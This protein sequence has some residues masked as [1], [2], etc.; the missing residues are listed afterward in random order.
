MNEVPAVK[1]A[2]VSVIVKY[3]IPP[4]AGVAWYMSF[5]CWIEA[6][7]DTTTSEQVL[8]YVPKPPFDNASASR[9]VA[10]SVIDVYVS[11][12]LVDA[13]IAVSCAIEAVP[14]TVTFTLPVT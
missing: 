12:P 2:T 10:E 7:P 1:S 14:E 5:N 3:V 13:S 9:F 4:N 8:T 11:I 6:E